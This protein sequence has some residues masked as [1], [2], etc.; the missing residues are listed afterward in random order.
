MNLVVTIADAVGAF[1]N[2]LASLHRHADA[3][4]GAFSSN[5]ERALRSD[6]GPNSL[7]SP[8]GTSCGTKREHQAALASGVGG[9]RSGRSPSLVV[10]ALWSLTQT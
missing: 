6:V 2:I 8:P 10:A 4:R 9:G 3:A 1:D 7:T 5:T